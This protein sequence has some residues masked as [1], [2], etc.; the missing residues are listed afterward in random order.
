MIQKV[1]CFRDFEERDIDFVYKCKNDEKLNRMIVGQY[2]PFTHEEAKKWVEGC[3]GEHKTYKFWAICTNDNV[4]EIV[5]W[6]SLSQIDMINKSAFFHGIVIADK[7]Y[8][9]GF[10]WIESYLFV[11]EYAFERL[12]LNRVYGTKMVDHKQTNA[13]AKAFFSQ[14]EGI[15]R[16]AVYK[17]GKFYDLAIGALLSSDYFEH[18]QK[19]DY[20]LKAIIKRIREAKKDRTP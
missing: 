9:D 6:V 13:I 19:G 7:K 1:V 18:K 15:M 17:N 2:H 12:G 8:K 4:K 14:C 16:Q 11:Y 10:A 5:G 20:E 3:M